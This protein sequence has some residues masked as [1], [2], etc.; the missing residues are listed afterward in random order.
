VLHVRY[1]RS[2]LVK[3]PG[4]HLRQNFDKCPVCLHFLGLD[5]LMTEHCGQPGLQILSFTVSCKIPQ[6]RGLPFILLL[7]NNKGFYIM[8]TGMGF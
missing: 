8:F 6:D 2:G 4:T 7:E 3:V 1:P 5:D